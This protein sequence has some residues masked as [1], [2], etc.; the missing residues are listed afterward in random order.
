MICFLLFPVYLTYKALILATLPGHGLT[1][2]FSLN[3]INFLSFH[4]TQIYRLTR[5]EDAFNCLCMIFKTLPHAIV[6]FSF[7][8]Y[9][10][11]MGQ[12]PIIFMPSR[13]FIAHHALVTQFWY[14]D[15]YAPEKIIYYCL[16]AK[17]VLNKITCPHFKGY[18]ITDSRRW[19]EM[20]LVLASGFKTMPLNFN[21]SSKGCRWQYR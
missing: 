2:P 20:Y 18:Q 4:E 10:V 15:D 1:A 13:G 17:K 8:R 7:D 5:R 11:I 9:S 6:A 12:S 3:I 21:I 16:M 14:F 19:F